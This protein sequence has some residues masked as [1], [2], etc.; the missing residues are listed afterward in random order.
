MA[1]RK[2]KKIKGKM[3]KAI[4][5]GNLSLEELIEKGTLLLK[6]EK[7]QDAIACYKHLLKLEQRD[8]F[9]QGLE[10]AYLGRIMALAN[11]SFFKEA[12]ALLNLLVQRFP[13][14]RV[15]PLK[16][17]LLLQ[18]GNYTEAA[19]LYNQCHG[20]LPPDRL[21]QIEALFG[22]LLLAGNGVKLQDFGS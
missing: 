11:K 2:K 9:L 10:Q 22:A 21:Q 5:L 14:A 7:F 17:N 1:K 16:L 20:Q 4:A 6:Q 8:E 13:D 12:S 3:H 19:K 18:A 15:D